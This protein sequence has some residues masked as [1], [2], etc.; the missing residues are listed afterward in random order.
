MGVLSLLVLYFVIYQLQ[1]NLIL[2]QIVK[3]QVVWINLLFR[4]KKIKIEVSIGFKY[5]LQKDHKR[6]QRKPRSCKNILCC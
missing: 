2:Q 6:S 4:K 5:F 1:F 3:Q